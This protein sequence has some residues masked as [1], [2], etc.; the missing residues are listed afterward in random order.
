MEGGI[1]TD[2]VFLVEQ[3]ELVVDQAVFR[4]FFFPQR[5][6][7]LQ[8]GAPECLY[9]VHAGAQLLISQFEFLLE[10]PQF[11]LQI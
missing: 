10:V 3:F 6:L 9:T 4:A 5:P 1:S 11:P 7:L 8:L 2:L